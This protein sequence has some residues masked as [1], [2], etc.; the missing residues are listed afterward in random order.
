MPETPTLAYVQIIAG[1]QRCLPCVRGDH[2]AHV[3]DPRVCMCECARSPAVESGSA[4]Y[5]L[6]AGPTKD[7]GVVQSTATG[8]WWLWRVSD[9][10]MQT[11]CEIEPP[12]ASLLDSG[13]L[14]DGERWRDRFE[15]AV[16]DGQWR[17]EVEG[18]AACVAYRGLHVVTNGQQSVAECFDAAYAKVWHEGVMRRA[19]EE[20]WDD[21]D[22]C[23]QPL[24]AVART[25]PSIDG[26]ASDLLECGH[27][28]S[29]RRI[30]ADPDARVRRCQMC[31]EE[32]IR[33]A[34]STP[35]TGRTPA[36]GGGNDP[37]HTRDGPR[38]GTSG[39]CVC[40]LRV[41][42]PLTLC[43]WCAPSRAASVA[44]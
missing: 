30:A 11:I 9:G 43:R 24:R 38:G 32:P 22:G 26:F 2:S 8:R 25:V 28:A 18:G 37:T 4:T 33:A 27:V 31:Y 35:P 42:S 14:E 16:L 3:S 15:R 7:Y 34:R 10:V 39:R 23:K 36:S 6:N 12:V 20:Q 41:T 13:V 29:I 21:P 17:I 5:D 44:R 40:G 19:W 1:S